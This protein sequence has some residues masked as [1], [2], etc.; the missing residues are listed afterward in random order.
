M[1]GIMIPNQIA[2]FWSGGPLS[3]LRYLTLKTFCDLNPT[4]GIYLYVAQSD[5]HEEVWRTPETQDYTNY[6]L[7]DWM[8][9]VVSELP[10]E[11]RIADHLPRG[12]SPI[13]QCDM[14][15]WWWLSKHGGWYSDL[16]ILY[17]RPM[18]DL[19]ESAGEADMVFSFP[20]G[21]FTIGFLGCVP[22]NKF[23]DFLYATCQE[24][25]FM[26]DGKSLDT[27]YQ[28]F[29][30][31]LIQAALQHTHGPTMAARIQQEYGHSYYE[32]GPND[33]VYPWNWTK[34]NRIWEESHEVPSGQLGIHWFAGAA[35]SQQRNKEI[36]P[37]TVRQFPCTLTRYIS[38]TL[39]T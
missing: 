12:L 1:R 16:D 25:E 27:Y 23:Y 37:A 10:V 32:V 15:Q 8:P 13:H 34:I 7:T 20:R 35:I 17:L 11:I 28:G 33:S 9:T 30:I 38:D 14:F 6:D 3:W 36:S 39:V 2:F 29:G 31:H 26:W 18:D 24:N 4:W 22:G 21:D 5:F 19:C